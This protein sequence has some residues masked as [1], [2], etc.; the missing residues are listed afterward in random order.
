MWINE[1]LNQ[2]EDEISR[3]VNPNKDRSYEYIATQM[4]AEYV[5]MLGYDGINIEVAL[6]QKVKI[7]YFFVDQ[8]EK[9][10]ETYM[11]IME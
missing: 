7:M 9:L 4:V 2:F 3:P 6:V 1:F 8:I 11:I 10:V 5:R